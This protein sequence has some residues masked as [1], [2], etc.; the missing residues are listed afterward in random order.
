MTQLVELQRNLEAYDR[1]CIEVFAV[2]YDDQSI[3]R[4][5]AKQHGITYP[6]L[7]GVDSRVIREFSP[8]VAVN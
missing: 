8:P 6:L 3:L 1:R 2:S 5:F 4:E 7:S